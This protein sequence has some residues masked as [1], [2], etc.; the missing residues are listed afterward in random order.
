MY[1]GWRPR[2][3]FGIGK[4]SEAQTAVMAACVFVPLTVWVVIATFGLPMLIMLVA[5]GLAVLVAMLTL[6][7]HRTNGTSLGGALV[8]WMRTRTARRKGWSAWETGV[9]TAHPRRNE[10]PGVL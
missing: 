10:L 1:G 4:L 8:I 6:I 9:F 5:I 3:G 7:P 2:R